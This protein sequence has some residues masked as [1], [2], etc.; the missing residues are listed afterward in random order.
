MIT[1]A[2]CSRTLGSGEDH[3][4][5]KNWT[6]A[7][8]AT[9]IRDLAGAAED[10][11]WSSAERIGRRAI[12]TAERAYPNGEDQD[13]WRVLDILKKYHHIVVDRG[14][15]WAPRPSGGFRNRRSGR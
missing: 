7:R 12:R 5:R 14:D 10:S 2:A 1:S 15:R 9:A 3:E 4:V 13:I 6:I 11:N 8:L